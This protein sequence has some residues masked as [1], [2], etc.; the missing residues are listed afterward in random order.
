MAP[1][2]DGAVHRFSA[3]QRPVEIPGK[4]EG[5]PIRNPGSHSDYGRKPGLHQA[6]RQSSKRI[7]ATT[8]GALTGIQEDELEARLRLEQNAQL[9]TSHGIRRAILVF[10]EKHAAAVV[11]I[12]GAVAD[13]VKNVEIFFE[14]L[15]A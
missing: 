4:S 12:E 9:Q 2:E 11:S 3:C 6:Q 8:P 10:Q 7:G 1:S 14:E 5:C 13:E 15:L